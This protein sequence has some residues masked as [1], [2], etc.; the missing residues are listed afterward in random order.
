MPIPDAML[1][2]YRDS[3]NAKIKTTKSWAART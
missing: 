2:Q 1:A 3:Q